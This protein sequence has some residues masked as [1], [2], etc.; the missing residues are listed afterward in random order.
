MTSPI[1]AGRLGIAVPYGEIMGSSVEEMNAEFADYASMGVT[2]AR[3]DFW[4]QY[5]EW[6]EDTY[7]WDRLDLLVDTA[8]S[9]GIEI[10]AELNGRPAWL[11]DHDMTEAASIEAYAD[12]AAATVEH[13]AGRI[14]RWEIFNEPNSAGIAPDAYAAMLIAAHDAIKAVDPDAFVISGGLAATPET[15]NGRWGAV[16]YLEGIYA[17]GAGGHFDAIGYHPYTWPLKPSDPAAWNG[18]QIMED[19]IRAAMIANGDADLDVWMTEFGAPTSGG[20]NAVSQADQAA[21]L[22]EAVELASATDWAGPILW[23]SYQ[24][25]GTS[26][27]NTED[28]FGL[29]GPD[30]ARKEAYDTFRQISLDQAAAELVTGEVDG[31]DTADGPPET[32]PEDTPVIDPDPEPEILPEPDDADAGEPDEP[33][34]PTD[35]TESE[36]P[37]D[38]TETTEPTDPTEIDAPTDPAPTDPE[39]PEIDAGRVFVFTG[40]DE[41]DI[42]LDTGE[43]RIVFCMTPKKMVIDDFAQGDHLDLSAVDADLTRDGDQ[44]FSLHT[45]GALDDPG[46]LTIRSGKGGW[47]TLTG[48]IDGS[49]GYDFIIRL[50][51]DVDLT[52]DDFIF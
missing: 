3:T 25:R 41:P 19:G 34:T 8:A 36:T 15:G 26:T 20:G 17:A 2:V 51:G 33:A 7:F 32:D 40:A 12:F 46:S 48:E 6:F 45:D 44:A 10:I 11:E 21:I 49:R 47:T 1:E 9:H 27:S 31:T 39:A 42:S 14:T 37:T 38:P 35:P 4:W 5:V 23:Y 30:G 22:I 13:F 24:D 16:D 18:W 29:V 52:A 28:W 50:R 43:D